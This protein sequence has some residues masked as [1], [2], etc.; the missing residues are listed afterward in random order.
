MDIEKSVRN[1]T[2]VQFIISLHSLLQLLL[3]HNTRI[4]LLISFIFISRDSCM[5]VLYDTHEQL[6][7]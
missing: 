4:T 1:Q 2:S 7:K 3:V 6:G 5:S